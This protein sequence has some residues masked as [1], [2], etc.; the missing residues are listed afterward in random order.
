MADAR[1]KMIGFVLNGFVFVLIGLAAADDP[2]G[3]RRARR[4]R[5]LV[6]LAALVCGVVVVSGRV[7]L[8]LEPAARLAA[9]GRRPRATR[10]RRRGSRSSSAGPG[11]RGAVS[12][13]AAL[14]LPVGFPERD[15]ILLLT[16]AVILVTLVGQGLTL[17]SVVRWA[18]WDGVERDGDE[19]TLARDGRLPGRPRGD[20]ARTRQWPGHQPLLD[21][22]ESG[23]RTEPGTS[24]PRTRTRP[25]SGARSGSSTRRSSAA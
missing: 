21:R 18:G 10:A 25:P 3:P 1:W 11:L 14:A 22:L 6:G 15:L 16:F 12:L 17:P 19:A 8:R 5:R 20:R 9:P 24:P 13:A 4:W 7:G 23:L 2:R